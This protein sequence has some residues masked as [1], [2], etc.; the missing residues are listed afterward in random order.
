[1]ERDAIQQP[2]RL[3]LGLGCLIGLVRQPR[4]LGKGAVKGE[5]PPLERR[6]VGVA[7]MGIHADGS[8]MPACLGGRA[9]FIRA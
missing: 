1:M 5:V 6:P 4:V 8:S 7:V 9:E 3:G 2:A